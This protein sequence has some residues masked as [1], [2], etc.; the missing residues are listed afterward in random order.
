LKFLARHV[1]QGVH[2]LTSTLTVPRRE[3]ALLGIAHK[4]TLALREQLRRQ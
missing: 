4:I 1:F 2:H 3:I